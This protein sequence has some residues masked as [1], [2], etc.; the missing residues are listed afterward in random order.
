MPAAVCGNENH[1]LHHS[2]H[3]ALSVS[4]GCGQLT[5]SL[6]HGYHETLKKILQYF[7]LIIT[8]NKKSRTR[9]TVLYSVGGCAE[10]KKVI[11]M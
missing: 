10:F 11:T 9:G 4:V 2:L 5:K 6:P 1:S 8:N 3:Q 7:Y